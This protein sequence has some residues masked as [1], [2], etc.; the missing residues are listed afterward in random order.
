M[1]N[2]GIPVAGSENN[3][4]RPVL[5]YLS[6]TFDL[7]HI[8]HLNLIARASGMCD[9]LYSRSPSDSFL[10]ER[11]DLYSVRRKEGDHRCIEICRS[12]RRRQRRGYDRLGKIR[13]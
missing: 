5:G 10:Q 1:N 4:E 9:Y 12:R 2:S 6:G 11:N 13:L 3:K 7:F 8:G